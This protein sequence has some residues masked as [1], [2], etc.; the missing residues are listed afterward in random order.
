M[1]FT[2]RQ[3]A[4][5][6]FPAV[7]NRLLVAMQLVW[8]SQ[9]RVEDGR[10]VAEPVAVQCAA[11]TTY[12]VGRGKNCL[13]STPGGL[14]FQPVLVFPLLARLSLHPT[15]DGFRVAV[16]LRHAGWGDGFGKVGQHLVKT[17][18]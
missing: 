7:L 12:V 10:I 2:V 16:L 15:P 9:R 8:Q 17:V 5:R 3:A 14:S 6:V 18:L 1:L 13:V 11:L 4:G